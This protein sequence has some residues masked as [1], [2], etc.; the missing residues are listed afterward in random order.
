METTIA[1]YIWSY[2]GGYRK[3]MENTIVA[4]LST[5]ARFPSEESQPAVLYSHK[6][7]AVGIN[8]VYPVA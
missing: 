6:Y 3:E 1:Y 4:V 5:S 8:V 7:D 2:L